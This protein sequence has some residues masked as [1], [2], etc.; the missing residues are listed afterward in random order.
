MHFFFPIQVTCPQVRFNYTNNA[1]YI[2]FLEYLLFLV[3]KNINKIEYSSLL[4]TSIRQNQ[5]KNTV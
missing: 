3:I 4:N 5:F 2:Q 1:K